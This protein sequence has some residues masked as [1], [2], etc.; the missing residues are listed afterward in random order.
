MML[1]LKTLQ[2]VPVLLISLI[3][4]FAGTAVAEGSFCSRD[5]LK[6]LSNK[7]FDAIAAHDPSMLP[8]A[9]NVKFTENGKELKVGEG[10]WQTAGKALLTRHIVDTQKC[11]T[12][13]QAVIEEPNKEGKSRPI[14]FGVRLQ[15]ENKKITEIETVLARETE[16]AME[17][18]PE[19]GANAVLNTKGQDWESIIPIGERSSRLALIAAADDYFEM[20]ADDPIFGTPFADVCHRWENGF[21]TT[22]GG[23]FQ[24]TKYPPGRCTPKGLGLIMKHPPRRVPI[25]DLEAG[26]AVAY[27]HFANSLPDFHMFKMRNGKVDLIQAVI[28]AGSPS[29]GWPIEPICKD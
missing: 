7:Y 22:K 14:L 23:E 19:G 6:S 3:L 1:Q 16:F 20:F 9:S 11:G 5:N 10:I 15:Y 8:L 17:M 21:Q 2:K 28:G 13:T 25:V 12:H 18:S 27:V 4:I 26:V 29:M 24:G